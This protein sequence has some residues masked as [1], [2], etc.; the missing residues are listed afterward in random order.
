MR[1]EKGK[2]GGKQLIW[3]GIVAV[4]C[5]LLLLSIF[6]FF[7]GVSTPNPSDAVQSY[8][9]GSVLSPVT[10]SSDSRSATDIVCKDVMNGRRGS[11]FLLEVAGLLVVALGM[12]MLV[13]PNFRK[14][15][16]KEKS[17]DE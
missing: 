14:G 12:T 11:V 8:D 7:G 10:S 2:L 1:G 9:C 13:L 17:A 4:G 16:K 15:E 3:V 5:V 6:N